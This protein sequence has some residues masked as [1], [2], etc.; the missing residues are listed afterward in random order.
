MDSITQ[1]I[2]LLSTA[3]IAKMSIFHAL[4]TS[5]QHYIIIL[6][7]SN[8]HGPLTLLRRTPLSLSS[9]LFIYAPTEIFLPLR[10]PPYDARLAFLFLP[11]FFTINAQR[12]RISDLSNLQIQILCLPSALLMVYGFQIMDWSCISLTNKRNCTIF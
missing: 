11:H 5:E 12:I 7:A 4:S 10:R 2:V 9:A 3:D 6:Q 8:H 1:D